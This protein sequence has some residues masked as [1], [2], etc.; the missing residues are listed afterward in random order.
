MAKAKQAVSEFSE[1]AGEV[2]SQLLINRRKL[3]DQAEAII[4]GAVEAGR[5]L[6]YN[7]IDF[8]SGE[9]NFDQRKIKDEVRRLTDVVRTQAIVGDSATRAKH[10]QNTEAALA[11]LKQRVPELD[12]Q[13]AQLQAEKARLEKTAADFVRREE[14][15]QV[16]LERLKTLAPPLSIARYNAKFQNLSQTLYREINANKIDLQGYKVALSK[17]THNQQDLQDMWLTQREYM[18]Q[19]VES[20]SRRLLYSMRPE[21]QDERRR[22]QEMIPQLEQDIAAMQEKYD[23]ELADIEADLQVYWR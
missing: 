20:G 16:G 3:L 4:R 11:D 17:D 12:E 21:W 18:V 10:T 23:A 15:I 2:A 9:V 1:L 7:E 5:D 6:D 22:M 8:L 19:S 14:Q 13:I